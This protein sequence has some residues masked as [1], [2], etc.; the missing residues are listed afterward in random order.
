MDVNKLLQAL[1]DETNENLLDFLVFRQLNLP[2]QPGSIL[3]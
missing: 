1:E 2:A 3:F